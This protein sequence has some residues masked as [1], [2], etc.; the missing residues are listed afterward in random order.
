MSLNSASSSPFVVTVPALAALGLGGG[1]PVSGKS[2]V[3]CASCRGQ[4]WHSNG[5]F[6]LHELRR[7]SRGRELACD[8]AERRHGRLWSVY[9]QNGGPSQGFVVFGS[10]CISH[11]EAPRGSKA[12]IGHGMN[13]FTCGM[14]SCRLPW[15][16]V[17][18]M[19]KR[20]CSQR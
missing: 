1:G 5:G 11:T 8:F 6:C 2:Q 20:K 19:A 7:N 4:I 14:L 12:M 9:G 17:V 13:S 10:G 3:Y 16:V 18:G 15:H